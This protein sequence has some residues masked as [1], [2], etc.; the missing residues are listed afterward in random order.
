MKLLVFSTKQY[1]I[2]AS[3]IRSYKT[4][5]PKLREKASM[6]P[7]KANPNTGIKVVLVSSLQI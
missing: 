5:L 4:M 2:A 6:Q 7:G 1:W 3:L